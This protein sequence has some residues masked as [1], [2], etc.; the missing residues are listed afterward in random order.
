MILVMGVSLFTSRVI[1]SSLGVDDYGIYHVVGGIVSLFSI[2][3]SS[4][5]AAISRF[6]TFEL[7]AGN[8]DKLKKIFA[9]SVCIQL[10]IAVIIIMLCGTVGFW[11]L[12]HRMNIDPMRIPAANWVLLFSLLTFSI[13]LISVPFNA[14]IIAHEHMNAFA[15]VGI[16][17]AGLKLGIAYL[18]ML[19]SFDR[20]IFYAFLVFF[21]AVI[22]R[23]I[24]GIYCGRHFEECHSRPRY[25]SAIFREMAGFAGWNFIGSSAS[26][27]RD[28][29][30]NLILNLFFGTAVN[31]AY[32]LGMQV[33]NAVYSFSQN[34]M[35]ALRPQIT[36][37][38]AQGNTGYLMSLIFR[39]SR[40]S[41]YLLWMIAGIA[42]LNTEYILELWLKNVPEYTV[43]FVQLF[44]LFVLSESISQPLIT[45]QLATGDIKNYQI[46]VGG[47]KLLNLPVS[48]VFLRLGFSPYVTLL[49]SIAIS[50]GMLMLRLYFLKGMIGLSV[51]EFI[52]KVVLNV[53]SVGVVSFVLSYLLTQGIPE[54]FLFFVTKSVITLLISALSIFFLGCTRDE[55]AFILGKLR[56]AH[57]RVKKI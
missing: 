23:I 32:S 2:I 33:S 36:K 55:R 49:V 51:K 6:M 27:I 21:V 29:G 14:A 10:G 18:I 47:L 56:T 25:D 13:N 4:L 26:I 16:L 53:L 57:S 5:S 9:T 24:Y 40:Y 30:N 28:Q 38:Y 7:G 17:E 3:S 31:A 50:I 35:T 1:L 8:L 22:I 11:F 12:N 44:L 46:C 34:F 37:S 19:A 43:I 42:L 39:G 52:L 48:Y 15:Y 45:A 20:L 41:F 54:S